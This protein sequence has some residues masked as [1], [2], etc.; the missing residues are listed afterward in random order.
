[1]AC[2]RG[3]K[4]CETEGVGLEQITKHDG[5]FWYGEK[6]C[7]DADDAYRRFRSDYHDSLGKRAYRRLDRLERREERVHGHGFVFTEQPDGADFSGTVVPTRIIGLVAGS[8]CRI[9]GGWD[10]PYQTEE[11]FERWFEWAFSKGSG[12]LRFVGKK[13]KT[14]RTSKL[15]KKRYR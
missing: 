15:L 5:W 4:D 7:L 14:G 1:M 3:E 13:L 8:Y 6:R 12:A 9:V 2:G 10:I 11:E